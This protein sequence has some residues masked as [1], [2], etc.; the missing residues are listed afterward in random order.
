LRRRIYLSRKRRWTWNWTKC[1][2]L[3]SFYS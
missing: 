3:E 1:G 2:T